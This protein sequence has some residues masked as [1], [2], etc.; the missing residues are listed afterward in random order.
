MDILEEKLTPASTPENDDQC[1]SS[2]Q[3]DGSGPGL[4]FKEKLYLKMKNV[5]KSPKKRRKQGLSEQ[6]RRYLGGKD[7]TP[8]LLQLKALLHCTVK[9]SSAESERAFSAAGLFSTK[10]RCRLGDDSLNMLAVIRARLMAQARAM[11]Q[12]RDSLSSL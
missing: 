11:G 8:A 7:L 9:P 10:I 4:S 12:S 6:L 5:Y 3:E 1:H 2:S